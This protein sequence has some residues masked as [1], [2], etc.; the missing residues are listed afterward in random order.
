MKRARHAALFTILATLLALAAYGCGGTSTPLVTI[1]KVNDL[2]YRVDINMVGTGHF[3]I[4]RQYAQ[5]IMASAPGFES[6]ADAGIEATIEMLQ[7]AGYDINI[8]TLITRARTIYANIPAEYQDEIQGMQS[9]FSSQDDTPGNG[10]LSQNKLL[11]YELAPDVMRAVSCSA[12]AVFGSSSESG[13]TIVGR[14]LEWHDEILQYMAEMQTVAVLH[15]G[16]KS[17]VFFGFIGQLYPVSGFNSNFIFASI[18]D[19]DVGVDYALTGNERS[20]VMELRYA[21]ENQST[22]QGVAD[23]MSNKPYAYDFNIFLADRQASDVLEVDIHTPFSGLRSSTSALKTDTEE[24][25]LPWNF[26]DAIT[27][28]N[29]FTLPG[30][31]DNTAA[32]EG[33]PT[34]WSSFITLYG[35]YLA[36]GKIGVDAIERITSYTGSDGSGK[37]ESGAIWRFEDGESEIQSII[38]K[39]DTAETWVSFQPAGQAPLR[40]PNYI[41]VFTGSPF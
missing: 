29:W 17:V 1:S 39:M 36:Q 26:P 19:S 15:N 10:K 8:S 24:E 33:N 11:V 21:L 9:V 31:I 30:T 2:Y 40:S 23:S 25:I 20:Y 38:M 27:C 5:Q 41:Q 16:A 28:V 3:E 32:W 6:Q 7:A 18:L 12:S 13:A 22:I 37:A 4:G 35:Q 34:R 14:N